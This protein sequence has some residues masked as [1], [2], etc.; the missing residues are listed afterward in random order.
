M[1]SGPVVCVCCSVVLVEVGKRTAPLL[2]KRR[3]QVSGDSLVQGDFVA[4]KPQE[5]NNYNQT[6]SKQRLSG[7]VELFYMNPD[8]KKQPGS[9]F[10]KRSVTSRNVSF[11]L[12]V[13]SSI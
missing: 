5:Q 7:P 6:W 2:K 9:R 13:K 10:C 8:Y 1:G 4:K 12:S 11:L 3:N